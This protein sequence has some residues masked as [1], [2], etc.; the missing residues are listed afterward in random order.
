[1]KI[2]RFQHKESLRQKTTVAG[3]IFLLS[4][5]KNDGV[6][7]LQWVENWNLDCTQRG[8]AHNGITGQK[9]QAVKLW[10]QHPLQMKKVMAYVVSVGF[11]GHLPDKFFHEN[12][13]PG[14]KFQAHGG[15]KWA[16]SKRLR[17]SSQSWDLMWER[18]LTLL[19][20]ATAN[21][22]GPIDFLQCERAA[23]HAALLTSVKQEVE[24][25][26]AQQALDNLMSEWKD[27]STTLNGQ[28]DGAIATQPDGWTI[29]H[30]QAFSEALN[31]IKE[32]KSSLQATAAMQKSAEA[33]SSL[34]K[35]ELQRK[36]LDGQVVQALEATY[37]EEMAKI[38]Q[39]VMSEHCVQK[40]IRQKKESF[41]AERYE[42]SCHAA[43]VF[44][45]TN[46]QVVECGE[47]EKHTKILLRL[48]DLFQRS[49][50]SPT[51]VPRYLVLANFR[52]PAGISTIDYD[53]SVSMTSALL[54]HGRENACA[55][56]LAPEY[57]SSGRR[58]ADLQLVKSLHEHSVWVFKN[59]ST[60]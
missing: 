45:G 15:S 40:A 43:R 7:P 39:H 19:A 20:T 11:P 10:I 30:L 21:S 28:L 9:E 53:L 60:C 46:I 51:D 38:Q 47:K 34:G 16:K 13:L 44:Y 26:E 56:I 35:L 29:A 6:D 23:K 33:L 50:T 55:V 24:T 1:M 36:E 58:C 25:P 8:C 12:L 42:Q 17:V 54:H 41:Q 31:E 4:G 37:E 22:Q 57:P 14:R 32:A 18:C 2:Q 3:W 27:G 49:V 5:M 52:V 48:Q 59:L